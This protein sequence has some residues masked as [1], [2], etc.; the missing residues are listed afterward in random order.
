[1]VWPV[2]SSIV[3]PQHHTLPALVLLNNDVYSARMS[4]TYDFQRWVPSPISGHLS[5]Q[6]REAGEWSEWDSIRSPITA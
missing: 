1:M 4:A 3:S 2:F 5:S 6:R